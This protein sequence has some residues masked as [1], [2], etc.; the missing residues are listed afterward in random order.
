MAVAAVLAFTLNIV[1]TTA[2]TQADAGLF[3]SVVSLFMIAY[4]AARLGTPAGVVYFLSRHRTHDRVARLRPVVLAAVLPVLATSTLLAVAGWL[5]APWLATQFRGA[6]ADAV[7]MLRVMALFVPVAAVT[8]TALAACRGFGRMRP[9]LLVER[10]GRNVVQFAAVLAVA[11][12]GASVTVLPVAWAG[13]YVPTAVV[14]LL[15]LAALVRR[16]ERGSGDRPG[17]VRDEL[18]PFWRYS[19]PRALSTVAQAAVQRLDIVLVAALRGTAEAA[20]YTAATRF[21]VF[22]QLA[23]QAV[24]AAVEHR[25]SE[26]IARGDLD[27]ARRLYQAATGWVVLLAWPAYLLFATFAEP[28]LLLFGPEYVQGSGV[29]VLMAVVMLLATGCGMVDTVL[30]MAGRTL[31]TFYNAVAALGVNVVLNL[32][33]IPGWGIVGAAVA[34]A[35]AI[36][37][38]NLVPLA[39]LYVSLRLHPF[40]RGTLVAA[41][42][43]LL[44]FAVPALTC[45]SL[46]AGPGPLVA[47]MVAACLAYAAAAWRL[48]RVLA[49]DGLLRSRRRTGSGDGTDGSAHLLPAGRPGRRAGT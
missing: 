9:L 17:R 28:M 34:W 32:L 5:A 12:A 23:A 47:V 6:S 25:I 10:I 33:L 13:P 21:L 3:F 42:L 43:A 27:G 46:G 19:G 7:T 26:R 37:V 48:R 15:W 1:V 30:N 18:A 35:A 45:R 22:G 24:S 4:S 40:G 11:L 44:C 8:D 16:A 36:A 39:Q 41:G 2:W 14:A 38:G 20:V 31:W 29:T 49:L